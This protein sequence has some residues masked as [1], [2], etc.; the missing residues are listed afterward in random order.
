MNV[1]ATTKPSSSQTWK[2]ATLAVLACSLGALSCKKNSQNS[3]QKNFIAKSDDGY[4]QMAAWPY[5][6]PAQATK[7]KEFAARAKSYGELFEMAQASELV[8][9]LDPE[10][11]WYG[12]GTNKPLIGKEVVSVYLEKDPD[13]SSRRS[14][15]CSA[16]IKG[17]A[18]D[19]A[20]A[21]LSQRL[22]SKATELGTDPCVY[23]MFVL[24]PYFGTHLLAQMSAKGLRK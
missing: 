13:W 18:A 5:Y 17:M 16:L 10:M 4:V 19:P 23:L 15:S 6:S 7:F 2:L 24:T 3:S 22:Q 11:C 12:R 20:L 21:A 14:V 8:S 1:T 9:L